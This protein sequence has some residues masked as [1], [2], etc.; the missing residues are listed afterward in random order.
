MDGLIGND[1]SGS[2]LVTRTEV[3]GLGAASG[4]SAHDF[5]SIPFLMYATKR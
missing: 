4:N 2:I 1:K 5:A 3:K